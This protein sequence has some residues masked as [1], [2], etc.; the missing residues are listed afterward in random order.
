MSAA[1]GSGSE[2]EVDV[3]VGVD[4]TAI[5]ACL[6]AIQQVCQHGPGDGMQDAG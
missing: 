6:M 5:L 2:L 4:W 3:A 1:L